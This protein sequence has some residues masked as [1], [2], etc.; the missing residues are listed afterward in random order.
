MADR[1][2]LPLERKLILAAE[3]KVADD[4]AHGSIAGYGSVFGNEDSYGDIIEAGAFVEALEEFK[5][6]GFMP[7]GHDWGGLPVAT[8]SEAH[9]D[10]HGLYIRAEFHSTAAA[11]EARTV[12]QERLARGK[13]VGL[14]IG[15]Q[16][17]EYK[18]VKSEDPSDWRVKRILTK[19]KLFEVSIVTVP[20]N[21][22]ATVTEAKGL[23]GLTLADHSAR[24]LADARGLVARLGSLAELRADAGRALS[25]AK[26]EQIA[27]HLAAYQGLVGG[28]EALLAGTEPP[29]PPPD[30]VAL[31]AVQRRW[32]AL[33]TERL[34][35]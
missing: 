31:A 23:P 30:P 26:R 35:S 10:P 9:E 20:A 24:V 19:I 33:E 12:V 3:L 8:I 21:A 14:S 1:S 34:A 2:K 15:Y 27:E 28:L 18:I 16:V 22:L 7:V 32:L 11:Q 29:P 13:S 5:R 4:G 6:D 25:G 17:L